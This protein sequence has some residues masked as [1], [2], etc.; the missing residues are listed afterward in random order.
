MSLFE[1]LFGKPFD[2]LLAEGNNLFDKERFGEAKLSLE[3]ALAKGKAA[4]EAQK[5]E[6]KDRIRL[7]KMRLAENRIKEADNLAASG[8]LEDAV[9]LLEDALEI[10]DEASVRDAVKE[11]LQRYEAE[12]TRR[13]VD[14][15]DEIDDDEL[16]TIIA[17]TWTD[18]QAE[19]YAAMPDTLRAALLASHDNRHEEAADILKE[20][21]ARDDLPVPPKYLYLE[22]GKSLLLLKR[23]GEAI[24]ALDAFLEAIED[25]DGSVETGVL[26]CDMKAAALTMME[27]F[28]DAEGVLADACRLAPEDHT[29][30]L[31][32]GVFQRSREKYD[33]SIKSLE[34][35]RE[36]MGQMHPDFAVIRELGFTYLAMD[37]V[38][39]AKACL[40]AVI[41]HLA[42]RGE[43]TQFDPKTAVTLAELHE[44][45]GDHMA[46]AD[47]YRHLSVGYDT[48][49]H[50]TY[51]VEAAR[52]L[53]L[54]NGKP[55]LVERYLTRAHEL[56]DTDEKRL[57]LETVQNT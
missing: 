4:T 11:R 44:K 23:P 25:E 13:L 18:P 48:Q 15:V 9:S 42:S 19:E 17:G 40:Q 22:L 29:V 50:F 10:C 30:F 52:L 55:D 41:E 47:L 8:E 43:H 38:K 33:K 57:R 14:E 24:E 36:L 51:N 6:I 35:A 2:A 12:D 7:C 56:A 21:I 49:N 27:R 20:L 53:K 46:A 31:K 5:A 26:A 28:D 39:D 32:L 45:S 54:A 37:N 1:N 34:K 16:M 3:K